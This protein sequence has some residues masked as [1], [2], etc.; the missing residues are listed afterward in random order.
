M[1]LDDY[2]DLTA[3]VHEYKFRTDGGVWFHDPVNP[4]SVDDGGLVLCEREFHGR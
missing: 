1:V 3:G 2:P 4:D